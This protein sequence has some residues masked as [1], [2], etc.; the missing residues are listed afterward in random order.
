MEWSA[1]S[2]GLFAFEQIALFAIGYMA[3]W[4]AEI[5]WTWRRKTDILFPKSNAERPTRSPITVLTELLR[6]RYYSGDYKEV[7]RWEL[8]A[9]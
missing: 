9:S 1:S 6:I 7:I 2:F 8:H 3:E 5:V 4:T